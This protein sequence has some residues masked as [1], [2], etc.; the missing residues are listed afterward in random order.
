MTF[1]F[2][3]LRSRF[4]TSKYYPI[5]NLMSLKKVAHIISIPKLADFRSLM[6]RCVFFLDLKSLA[7]H[8]PMHIALTNELVA[9]LFIWLCSMVAAFAKQG[10]YTTLHQDANQIALLSRLRCHCKE[11]KLLRQNQPTLPYHRLHSAD[12]FLHDIYADLIVYLYCVDVAVFDPVIQPL[13]PL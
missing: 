13:Q 7:I 5:S 8:H 9:I 11:F 3:R 4:N 1:E 2:Q 12:P 6:V 10:W